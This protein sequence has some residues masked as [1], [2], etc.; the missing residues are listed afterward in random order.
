VRLND[1]PVAD[2]RRIVTAADFDAGLLKLSLGRKKHM[3]VRAGSYR[4]SRY[5]FGASFEAGFAGTSG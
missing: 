3:L 2:E 4:R 1:K 5:P